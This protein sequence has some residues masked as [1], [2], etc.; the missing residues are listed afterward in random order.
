MYSGSRALLGAGTPRLANGAPKHAGDMTALIAK[1]RGINPA[2]RQTL[3]KHGGPAKELHVCATRG[4]P[5][6]TYDTARLAH[7][8]FSLWQCRGDS[9][10]GSAALAGAASQIKVLSG[11]RVAS[12]GEDIEG[13]RATPSVVFYGALHLFDRLG[14]EHTRK[15]GKHDRAV[16]LNL[17]DRS[18]GAFAPA[19]AS[20]F[21]VSLHFIQKYLPAVYGH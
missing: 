6:A 11:G 13:L 12:F 18:S 20:E 17:S 8:R 10:V 7:H 5:E 4:A 9:G 19:E 16:T 15:I 21:S 14:F 1:P 2:N 3:D